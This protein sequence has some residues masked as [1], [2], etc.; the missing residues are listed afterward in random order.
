[1]GIFENKTVA[2]EFKAV[3]DKGE[4][5]GYFAIFGNIDD[6]L[7]ICHA[8]MFAKTI[9]ER[10]KRLK[11]L[12]YHDFEKLV[13]PAPTVLR[14]DSRGLYAKG[15]LT[16]KRPGNEGAFWANQVWALMKDG[17]LNEGSFKFLPVKFDY[18]NRNGQTIRNLREVKLYEISFVPLGMNPL[19]QVSAVKAALRAD[20]RMALLQARLRAAGLA[21]KL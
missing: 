2:A 14:E 8:G 10:G 17:A 15:R 9:A 7:D 4:Y 5:E 21:L 13:G 6:G 20:K 16:I 19:T 12:A 3:G 18:E 1:M 11:V